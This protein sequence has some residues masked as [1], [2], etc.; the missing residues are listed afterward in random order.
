MENKI[1][2]LRKQ[3]IQ[4]KVLLEKHPLK[5]TID[6]EYS[7]LYN[8]DFYD[9]LK[10]LNSYSEIQTI[11][12]IN[13]FIENYNEYNQELKLQIKVIFK[14]IVYFNKYFIEFRKVN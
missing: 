1:I 4:L 13:K 10:N 11:S 7:D 2:A 14:K 12:N 8:S 3:E 5:N 6:N 9:Q